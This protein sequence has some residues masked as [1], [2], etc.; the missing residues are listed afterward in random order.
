MGNHREGGMNADV[1]FY[2][3]DCMLVVLTTVNDRLLYKM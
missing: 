3:V 2:S 1:V